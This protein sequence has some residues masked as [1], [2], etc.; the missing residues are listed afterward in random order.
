MNKQRRKEIQG[1][2][3][4]IADLKQ[5]IEEINEQEAEYYNN[6][7]EGIQDGERGDIALRAMDCLEEATGYLEDAETSLHEAME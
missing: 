5:S 2:I 1:L 4:Q 6:M 7:P 3:D